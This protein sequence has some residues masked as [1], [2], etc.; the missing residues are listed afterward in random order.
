MFAF[1]E[2]LF[3]FLKTLG[4]TQKKHKTKKK[5]NISKGG[6]ETFKRFVVFGCP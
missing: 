3:G 1:L 4:K 6:S 5:E 2:Y